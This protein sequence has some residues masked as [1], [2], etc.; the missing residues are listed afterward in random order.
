MHAKEDGERVVSMPYPPCSDCASE[1]IFT[2]LLSSAVN[3]RPSARG[4][5]VD[6]LE[7]SHAEILGKVGAGGK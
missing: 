5:R 3:P 1:R 7:T 2:S 4:L 6:P